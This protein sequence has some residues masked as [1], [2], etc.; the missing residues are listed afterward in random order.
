M[1]RFII[2]G[3]CLLALGIIPIAALSQ[4]ADSS[5]RRNTIKMDITSH[6]LYRKAIMLSYERTLK[7]KPFQSWSVTAGFQQ[8]PPLDGVGSI[9]VLREKDASG[10]KL[11]GEYRFYLQK[12]NKYQAPRGV[13]VGPYTNLHVYNN[14]RS[15]EVDNNGV[16]EYA[17]LDT[18]LSIF[19][20]GV[21]LGYQFII[22]D[23]WAI[24]LVFIGPS[25]AN[26]RFKTALTGNYTFDP[27]AI[28]NEIILGL[29]DKFPGFNELLTEKEFASNGKVNTWAYG[30]RYQFQIGYHFGRKK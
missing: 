18:D 12:E 13:Y 14:S 2:L 9:N 17:E 7:N 10:Y 25:V 3:G 22:N 21:Q 26:Y 15:V 28:T 1:K 29:I 6:W 23:R 27:D 30:Y 24:D 4:S 11:G 19:N 5:V 20:I 8:F 16:M